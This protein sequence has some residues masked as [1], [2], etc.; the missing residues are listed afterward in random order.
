M[1]NAGCIIWNDA[2]LKTRYWDENHGAG[3]FHDNIIV[4]FYHSSFSYYALIFKQTLNYEDP[5]MCTLTGFFIFY[6]HF[7]RINLFCI[8]LHLYTVSID[9]YLSGFK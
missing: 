4:S 8:R 6:L 3:Y 7:S 1:R 9:F 5:V 2:V